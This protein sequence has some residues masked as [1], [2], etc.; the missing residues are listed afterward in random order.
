MLHRGGWHSA[1][2]VGSDCD[3]VGSGS[4]TVPAP[5]I[6]SVGT[7]QRRRLWRRLPAT[8]ELALSHHFLYAATKNPGRSFPRAICLSNRGST[9]RKWVFPQAPS[10]QTRSLR[11]RRRRPTRRSCSR[12]PTA[13][14][15]G[16]TRRYD[17]GGRASC[18]GPGNPST[19]TWISSCTVP[20]I[21][22]CRRLIPSGC[23]RVRP[24]ATMTRR[25]RGANARCSE[26]SQPAGV[27]RR[28]DLR[29]FRWLCYRKPIVVQPGP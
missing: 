27:R 5:G 3:R 29:G 14:S 1:S 17:V 22:A 25:A 28:Q 10:S 9:E 20:R 13:G 24:W 11:L 16:S 4:R 21:T 19:G 12:P 2:K 7:D 18:C 6:G 26:R 15:S 23:G 8:M